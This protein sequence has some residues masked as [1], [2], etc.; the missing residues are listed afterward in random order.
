MSIDVSGTQYVPK[1]RIVE[2]KIEIK[3]NYEQCVMSAFGFSNGLV[4]KE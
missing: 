2:I 3:N 1:S 4:Q